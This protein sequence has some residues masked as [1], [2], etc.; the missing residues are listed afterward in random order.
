MKRRKEKQ[1]EPKCNY[2]GKRLYVAFSGEGSSFNFCG[3]CDKMFRNL[4][5]V[6]YK[7]KIIKF[8]ELPATKEVLQQFKEIILELMEELEETRLET[9]KMKKKT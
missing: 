3:K 8:E 9:D 6:P 4:D 2:C 7:G 1:Q 5:I